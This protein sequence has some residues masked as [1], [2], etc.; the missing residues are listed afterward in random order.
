[1]PA[2][3]LQATEEL[4]KDD[5]LRT[6]FG[7][8]RDGGDYIDY[9]EKVKREEFAAYHAEVTRWETDRYLTLF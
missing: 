5:V 3:L 8:G 9:F 6:A 2:T 7:P 4:V 1:M